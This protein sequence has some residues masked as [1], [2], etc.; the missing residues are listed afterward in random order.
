MTPSLRPLPLDDDGAVAGRAGGK[1]ERA[2]QAR[3]GGEIGHDFALVPGVV[4]EGDDVGAGAHEIDR[5]PRRDAVAARGVLAVDD[6]EVGL[7]ALA[8]ERDGGAHGVAARFADDIAEK[9]E[10]HEAASVEASARN[11]SFQLGDDL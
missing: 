10:F 1:I 6:E 5:E 3:L 8:Q 4:A 7:V 9:N 2:Q 11:L